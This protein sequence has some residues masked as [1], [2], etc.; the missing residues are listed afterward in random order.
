MENRNTIPTM[1]TS[2]KATL[3]KSKKAPAAPRKLQTTSISLRVSTTHLDALN[4]LELRD[5]VQ[6]SAHIQRA[7]AEYLERRGM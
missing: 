2:Q 1:K 6:R 7:I 3:A 4:Q 5:G